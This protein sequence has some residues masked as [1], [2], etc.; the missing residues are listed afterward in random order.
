RLVGQESY[1]EK[2]SSL[3]FFNKEI[4]SESENAFKNHIK[5]ILTTLGINEPFD[6]SFTY[7]NQSK[8]GIPNKK[9]YLN[10]LN[11]RR[12]ENFTKDSYQMELRIL[13]YIKTQQLDKIKW[14]VRSLEKEEKD[15]SVILS[16]DKLKSLNY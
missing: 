9:R 6:L 13:H 10:I 11:A 5:F 3:S 12:L 16:T 14:T 7:I 2:E 4:P 1:I 8:K 15:T